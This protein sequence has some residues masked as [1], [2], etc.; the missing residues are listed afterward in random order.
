VKGDSDSVLA[1][2]PW[3]RC[4]AGVLIISELEGDGGVKDDRNKDGA[5]PIRVVSQRGAAE[6]DGTPH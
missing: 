2:A 3:D 4:K 6:R 5:D 1:K